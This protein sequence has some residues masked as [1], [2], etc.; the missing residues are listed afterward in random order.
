MTKPTSKDV[1]TQEPVAEVGRFHPQ[2]A[3]T[4]LINDACGGMSGPFEGWRFEKLLILAELQNQ[5]S[6][7][8]SLQEGVIPLKTHKRMMD[9]LREKWLKEEWER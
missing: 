6:L 9:S 3:T 5:K 7:E 8:L 4:P 1:V 2:E